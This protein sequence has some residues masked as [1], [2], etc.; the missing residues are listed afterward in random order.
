MNGRKLLKKLTSDFEECVRLRDEYNIDNV[1]ERLQSVEAQLA[2]LIPEVPPVVERTDR[3]ETCKYWGRDW[4]K[5]GY[6][7]P[8]HLRRDPIQWFPPKW[9][10][11]EWE[12]P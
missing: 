8:C 5:E 6:N 10:C 4:D 7:Q 11:G 12:A 1:L 2:E 3:C 9:W